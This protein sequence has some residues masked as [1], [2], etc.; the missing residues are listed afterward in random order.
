[1]YDLKYLVFRL[2]SKAVGRNTSYFV[3]QKHV[4]IVFYTAYGHTNN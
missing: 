1:M 2:K 4:T 3:F